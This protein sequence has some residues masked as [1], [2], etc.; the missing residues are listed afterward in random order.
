[1]QDTKC[2][3]VDQY[4]GAQPSEVKSMLEQMRAIIIRSAPEAEEIISYGM[5]AFRQNG[6]LVYFA[7]WKSHIGFYPSGSGISEFAG[8]LAGFKT[9]KGAIQ[10]PLDQPLPEALIERIVRWRVAENQQK[11]ALRQQAK[12][13]KK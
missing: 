4:I 3:S 6:M 12:S 10:F 1:M 13:K 7:A 8:E 9:S 11:E 2:D 5:P